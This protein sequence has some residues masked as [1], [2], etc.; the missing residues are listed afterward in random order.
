MEGVC[1]MSY[2]L[3]SV[4]SAGHCDVSW[5]ARDRHDAATSTQ[6]LDL[7]KAQAVWACAS[8]QD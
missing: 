3:Y 1:V 5:H 7:F 4:F 8:P 2:L 6:V